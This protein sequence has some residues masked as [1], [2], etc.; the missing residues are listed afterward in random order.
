MRGERWRVIDSDGLNEDE[1]NA[2]IKRE[3]K[4]FDIHRNMKFI[5]HK[6]L[7]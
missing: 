2:M 5:L 4:R 3:R 7:V 1:R 6:C